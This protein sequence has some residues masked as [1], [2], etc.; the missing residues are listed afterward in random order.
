MIFVRFS[1]IKRVIHANYKIEI[2]TDLF[3]FY[4]LTQ[5]SAGSGKSFFVFSSKNWL[6]LILLKVDILGDETK[7]K[8]SFH[9]ILFIFLFAK[10]GQIQR[11]NWVHLRFYLKKIKKIRPKKWD[12]YR[13]NTLSLRVVST[14]LVEVFSGFSVSSNV[15]KITCHLCR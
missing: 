14:K 6:V 10:I 8:K 12:I 15:L 11:W 5:V 1:P 2:R 9:P 3:I 13:L 4:T 7:S